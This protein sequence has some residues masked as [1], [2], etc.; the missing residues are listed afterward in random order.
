VDPLTALVL[1]VLLLVGN[2]FFVAAEFALVAARRPRLERAAGAGGKPA[3]AAVAGIRELSLMLAGAQFGITMCTL[4]LGLVAEPAFE[5]LLAPP[6]HGLGLPPAA[7]HAV[8][9]T[10]TLAGVTF[11][12][13]VLGE[14]AP[15]SWAITHPER[16]ALILALPFRAFTRASRPLLAVL[17]GT[18]NA[19]LRAVRVTPRDEPDTHA[20]PQRLAHLLTESRRLGLIDRHDHDL[21]DSAIALRQATIEKLIV[22]ADQVTAVPA[23]AGTAQIRHAARTSGHVRLLVRHGGHTIEGAVVGVVHVRDAIT[24]E[25]ERRAADLAFPVPTVAAGTSVLDTVTRLRRA[26]A[27][28]AVVPGPDGSLRGIVSLDDLLGQLLTANPH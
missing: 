13:M 5:R 17:N 28:L 22:P 14:M 27:Q 4:G 23:D 8:A 1:T 25:G 12:H 11:L 3:A 7:S 9:I 18:T 19:L 10:I 21:L 20:D 6:L 24:A 16:S 2:G 15:K 26:H